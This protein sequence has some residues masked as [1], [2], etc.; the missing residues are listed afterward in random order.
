M[1]QIPAA[2]VTTAFASGLDDGST[3]TRDYGI[4]FRF[5]GTDG[6]L[7]GTIGWPDSTYSTL[8][9]TSRRMDG[10]WHEPIFHTKWFPDAFIGTMSDL[11]QAIET[12]G[13]PSIS[14]E[15]NLKTLKLVFGCY[16]AAQEGRAVRPSEIT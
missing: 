12:G 6:V 4:R 9:F 16:K 3:W 5:T 11:F 1:G 13:E 15:D 10:F 7:K 2:I 8:R 14:G